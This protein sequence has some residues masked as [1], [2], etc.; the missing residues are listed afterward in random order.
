M[1]QNKRILITGGT[2]SIGKELAKQLLSRN[3][4]AIRIFSRDEYK[5]FEMAQ[6]FGA[7][8][9]M[10]FLLG[11]VRDKDRL[12]YA[13]KDIDFIFHLAA[14]KQVPACEYNPFEAIQ[15][16]VI[17]TQNVIKA[18]LE[19]SATKV[20]LTS[21]DK[22]IN[23]TNTMGASKLIAERLFIAAEN[24]KGSNPTVFTTVRFG[25]VIGSRGS[26]IPLFVKQI[27]Q[28]KKIR[29][30]HPD[31]YR[32]MMS[33]S[34]ACQLMLQAMTKAHGGEIFVLKMP[35]VRLGDLVQA[36]LELVEEKFSIKKRE[37]QIETIGLRRGEKMIEELMSEEE[38]YLAT[39]HDNMFTISRAN[40]RPSKPPPRF[41]RRAGQ[42]Q[43]KKLPKETIKKIIME[44]LHTM[45]IESYLQG[46]P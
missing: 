21:S 32:F 9:K 13:A 15:T 18:A 43:S 27:L 31:M 46:E 44:Q 40:D 10:R 17:G 30:T 45:D 38:T 33:V 36:I 35:V 12:S 2:G 5:Q 28:D 19:H 7:T 37:I 1:F 4:A 34:E 41:N 11:D 25:N 26:V 14:L 6:E 20:L 8:Q 29:V 23:P 39:E 16:N 42:A 24:Y 3:P 22:A